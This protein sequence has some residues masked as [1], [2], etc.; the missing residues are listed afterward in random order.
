MKPLSLL[1][2]CFLLTACQDYET[3]KLSDI[4]PDVKESVRAAVDNQHRPGVV[5]GLLTPNGTYFYSYGV[6]LA[7]GEDVLSEHSQ[8][9]IGSLTKLFTAEMLEVLE[10]KGVVTQQTSVSEI[11][12]TVNDKSDTRL[13]HLASHTAAL[14]RDL[15]QEAVAE[16][17]VDKLLNELLR[18]TSLPADYSYSSVGMAI[19]GVSLAK[20]SD[21]SLKDELTKEVITP[22]QLAGTGYEPNENIIA[23]RHQTTTPIESSADTPE[24]AYGAGG[25]YSTAKDLMSFLKNEMKQS[26]H[27]GWKHYQNQSFEAFYHGGDGNGHQAFIA[28]RPDNGVGVVLLSNSSS[29]DE[30][31]NIALHLIDPGMDLP[32]FEHRPHQQ[33]T[34]EALSLYVGSYRLKED[35]NSNQINLSLANNRL[36]YHEFTP[37]GKTV[38][39]T[40]LYAIDSKTFE[41][42]DVPVTISFEDAENKPEATLSFGEQAFTM[43]RVD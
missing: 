2:A 7:G 8:F 36:I 41:L 5:I 22:L 28:F 38:R 18:N 1:L 15:P 32:T 26:E 24:V 34:A 14:P 35:D 25:L 11:W 29:D 16:N 43:V 30:L 3:A 27:L 33:L 6:T 19:L 23:A 17:S 37:E 4:P 20:A 21:S 13:I 42:A 12:S 10:R 31:Q 9:A 40:P 39:K